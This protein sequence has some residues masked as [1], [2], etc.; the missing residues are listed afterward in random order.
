MWLTLR[1]IAVHTWP[2][3]A[4]GE[5][6]TSGSIFLAGVLLKAGGY[7]FLR[8][9]LPLFPFGTQA[10]LPVLIL[11]SVVA[12]LYGAVVSAVQKDL[13][14]LV[15]YSSGAH[16]GFVTLGIFVLNHQGGGGAIRPR[17]SH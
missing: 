2:T 15:A 13:K 5:L 9:A 6:P 14:K 17:L 12:I 3:E 16:M 4:H 7:G 11:L 10:W 8:F 1:V